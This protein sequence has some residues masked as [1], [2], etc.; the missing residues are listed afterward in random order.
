METDEILYTLRKNAY[1]RD[2]SRNFTVTSQKF[3]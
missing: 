2:I 3:A 1:G